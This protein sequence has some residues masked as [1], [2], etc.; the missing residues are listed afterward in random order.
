M[1]RYICI[2][3]LLQII[4]FAECKA[5]N[6]ITSK[7][8]TFESPVSQLSTQN[9]FNSSKFHFWTK[10]L[11]ENWQLHRKLW[12]Y[13]YVLE[14][15]DHYNML[16]PGK[17]AL[18][19][20]VGSEPLPAL[21]AK[22]GINVTASDQDFINAKTQG[23]ISTNQYVMEK[24]KLNN[25]N[26]CDQ[27]QFNELVD[28]CVIDMN[29]IDK[30][31]SGFDFTW[32]C[33]SL[34][35]LGSLEAG[36]KFIQNSLNCLKPGGIAV[37]TTEYN[38]SSNTATLSH[39]GTVIYRSRDLLALARRLTKLGYDVIDFNL[40]PGYGSLDKFIDVAPYCSDPHIK[41]KLG[42]YNCTSIGIIVRKP[43]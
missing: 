37:H 15:L 43:N 26:I 36:L 38:L 10:E 33:C 1:K 39:G 5:F 6:I 23:W 13:C 28:L 21:F 41:L 27:N 22:Y 7:E 29:N 19:F 35:H 34:E 3:Y 31:M 16:Q 2:V 12:E 42:K 4:L 30:N 40:N 32:S 17:R 18:G 25:R 20:G 8:P 11:H 24:T 9:Q 14:V